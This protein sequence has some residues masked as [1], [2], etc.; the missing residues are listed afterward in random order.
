MTFP[1]NT[2]HPKEFEH[3]LQN[4]PFSR[5]T[6]DGRSGR[7]RRRVWSGRAG[8]IGS[9]RKKSLV[10]QLSRRQ[11]ERTKAGD[12]LVIV[13]WNLSHHAERRKHSTRWSRPCQRPSCSW[14]AFS[15]CSIVGRSRR[16]G[17]RIDHFLVSPQL[18]KRLASWEIDNGAREREKPSDNHRIVVELR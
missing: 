13:S 12:G 5:R 14:S 6:T 2:A 3:L 1:Q 16:S 9:L 11:S 10:L 8:D 15:T 17:I 7:I 18:A 4:G